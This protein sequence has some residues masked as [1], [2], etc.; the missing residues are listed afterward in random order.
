[1]VLT[2]GK[3]TKNWRPE[4][5]N[6][7]LNRDAPRKELYKLI[8]A[9]SLGAITKALDTLLNNH[10]I[11]ETPCTKNKPEC[12]KCYEF[13]KHQPIKKLGR[14]KKN[15]S[16]PKN[17][18]P[19]SRCLSLNFKKIFEILK[20]YPQVSDHIDEEVMERILKYETD[21]KTIVREMGKTRTIFVNL[22]DY[23]TFKYLMPQPTPSWRRFLSPQE[24]I[25][26]KNL[27]YI[28]YTKGTIELTNKGRW[29]LLL[30][31]VANL[32]IDSSL[33]SVEVSKVLDDSVNLSGILYDL[34]QH[35]KA[36]EELVEEIKFYIDSSWLRDFFSAIPHR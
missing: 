7:L 25:I 19:K 17:V 29:H 8:G 6:L 23:L 3:L 2:M 33:I 15:T 24:L 28:R 14:P 27:H 11:L 35:K 4:I 13:H 10:I 20:E 16:R 21:L 30:L 18:G 12:Q 36:V 32:H 26:L 1:M 22:K 34:E 9:N 5:I 31:L